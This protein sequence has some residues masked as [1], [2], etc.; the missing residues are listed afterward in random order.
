[1]TNLFKYIIVICGLVVLIKPVFA[2]FPNEKKLTVNF[3][4]KPIALIDIEPGTNNCVQFEVV[5]DTE[6]GGEFVIKNVSTEKL[7]L[8]YTSVIS[9][10]QR[11]IKARIESGDLPDGVILMLSA[12]SYQGGGAGKMGQPVGQISLSAQ[13]KVIISGVG[14]CYTGDGI[15]N[16]HALDFEL[17]LEDISKLAALNES[18]LTI[19]YTISE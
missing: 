4:F 13:D 11:D 17:V 12:S 1:M 14:D 5:A 18:I 15:Y 16:G 7:W 10:E 9:V 19:L 6:S 3:S 8:N 2:Q